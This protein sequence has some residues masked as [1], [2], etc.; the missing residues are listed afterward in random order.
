VRLAALRTTVVAGVRREGWRAVLRVKGKVAWRCACYLPHSTP[1]R[2][3]ACGNAVLSQRGSGFRQGRDWMDEFL[4]T[5]KTAEEWQDFAAILQETL[6]DSVPKT[7]EQAVTALAQ[8]RKDILKDD[9]TQEQIQ[10]AKARAEYF[11]SLHRGVQHVRELSEIVVLTCEWRVGREL[12][13]DEEA[14]RE[15]RGVQMDGRDA[16]GGHRELPPNNA[17]TVADKVGN[18]MYGWRAKQIAP[19]PLESLESLI[20]SE[21]HRRGKEATLTGIVQHLKMEERT[22]RAKWNRLNSITAP[23]ID[24]D[25]G[26]VLRIGDCRV[27]LSDIAPNSIPLI[28]TDPPYG[29]EAEPL[30]EWLAKFAARV[31]IPGGSLICYTGQSKL[32]RDHRIFSEHL[33]YWWQAVMMHDASQKMFGANVYAKYKPV[34]W[35]VKGTRRGNSMVPDV[36]YAKRDKTEHDWAQGDGGVR[37]WI[38]HL[39]E[40]KET[41][42]DPFAGTAEWGRIT[43]EEGRYW[44]GSDI[45]SGGTTEVMTET[46]EGE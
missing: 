29:N 18:K 37:Q 15:A 5:P 8:L 22:E 34:L 4:P 26:M 40:L 11:K 16:I 31:L 36:L 30:Y 43:C 10:E 17:P 41:I 21:F 44:I 13:K 27:V 12:Q 20:R 9:A 24:A 3:M 42:V 6:R 45:V 28:M 23:R 38:H 39:T 25:A 2:A 19:L 46:E 1:Q 35:Y 32:P 7:V 33:T 14:G